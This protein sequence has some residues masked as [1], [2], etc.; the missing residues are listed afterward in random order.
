MSLKLHFG[1]MGRMKTTRKSRVHALVLLTLILTYAES[2]S[3]YSND[4][5]DEA[6]SVPWLLIAPIK[7]VS[8]MTLE[9][10]QDAAPST[11]PV[12]EITIE[13]NQRRIRSNGLPNHETG[14]FPSRGNPNSIK[15]QNYDIRIPLKPSE[16]SKPTPVG[17][18]MFGLALNGCFFEAGTA[19]WWKKDR[20]SGWHIEAIGPRGG[21]LGIDF[22]NGH[23]QPTGAYHYHSVPVGMIAVLVKE[24]SSRKP[25]LIGWAADGY[26][27]YGPWGYTDPKD[28]KSPIKQL[29]P[30]WQLK[31]GTRPTEPVSPGG[32]YD[33]TYE[34]DFHYVAG[35]GDLDEFNGRFG[36]T[37]EFPEGTYY[38]VI[39][40]S[41]PFVSRS[42]KGT[43]S[44]DM[45]KNARS[46]GNRG[47]GRG[48]RRGPGRGGPPGGGRPGGGRPGGGRPGG[49]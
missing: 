29:A 9:P 38:Y 22:N 18:N 32:R 3:A 13:G 20:N 17:M 19:E 40:E 44:S 28:N 27:I 45:R 10:S 47:D 41:F 6:E 34:E 26:P 39:T 42:W 48:R 4:P 8:T 35:S 30:S 23:V 16:A 1:T 24:E 36:I 15:P 46:P 37:D 43:P 12:T 2:A 33:G 14:R 49:S 25:I 11:K 21:I 7:R 31:E 5:P